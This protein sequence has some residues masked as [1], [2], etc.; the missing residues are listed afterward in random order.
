VS[1]WK[2]QLLAGA[3]ELFTSCK[4]T[5]E[6][7][8]AQPLAELYAAPRLFTNLFQPSFTFKSSVR[9]GP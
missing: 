9:A 7:E 6:M 8:A 2:R 5:K 3:S 4:K 1:E